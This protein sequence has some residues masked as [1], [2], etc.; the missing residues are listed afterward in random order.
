M[1]R[2]T[3]H[4]KTEAEWLAKRKEVVTSTEVAALF[5]VGSFIQTEYELYHLK[6]G[7][8]SAPDFDGNERVKW[9]LRLEDAIAKGIAEDLGLVVEPF[10]AFMWIPDIR[11]GASFDYKIVG[12]VDGFEDNEARR[13][14]TEYGPGILEIKNVDSLQFKRNWTEDGEHIEAPVQYEFQVQ[15]QMVVSDLRWAILAPLVGG[16]TPKPIIR[17]RDISAQDAIIAHVKDFWRAVDT[18]TPPQP[19]FAKDADVVAKVYLHNDGSSLD[20]PDDMDIIR[21]CQDYKKAAA[22]EK[23]AGEKKKAAKAELLTRIQAAKSVTT[24][25]FK[26]S[27]GTNKESYRVYD[28]QAGERWTITR[29]VIP[30]ATIEATVPPFRNVRITETK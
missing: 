1:K 25:G 19:D 21:V 24:S 29:S 12:L 15:A 7:S 2:E 10:K 16:N 20:L 17:A 22:A 9:G 13:M 28:R 8:I 27:A 11:L 14:F 30:A 26:I 4:Y 23:E 3:L 18:G 6:T 5:G